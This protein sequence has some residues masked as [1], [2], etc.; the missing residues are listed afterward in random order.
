M[1]VVETIL[2]NNQSILYRNNSCDLQLDRSDIDR[3][4]FEDYSSI[5][6]SGVALSSNPSREAVFLAVEKASTLKLPL[7]IDLDYRPY[8]WE[9]D[10]QKSEVYKKIM[11]RMDIIIGN[12]LEF[13][14]AD[15]SNEGLKL[16]QTLIQKKPS[17]IIYKMGEKG[18]KV[19]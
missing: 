8:N 1:A 18:S 19:L 4:N 15:N 13:N 9:S 12:D 2:D 5:F 6:I 10:Q 16:A 11:D 14:I 17:I 3:I 7:I